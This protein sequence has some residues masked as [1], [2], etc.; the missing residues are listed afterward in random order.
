M[1]PSVPGGSQVRKRLLEGFHDVAAAGL[2][3]VCHGELT[4]GHRRDGVSHMT[5]G[6]PRRALPLSRTNEL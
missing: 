1:T 2:V 3:Q 6:A 5:M 4:D